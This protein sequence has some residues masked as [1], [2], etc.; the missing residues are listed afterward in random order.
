[1]ISYNTTS[2]YQYNNYTAFND[3]DWIRTNLWKV[4]SDAW[5]LEAEHPTVNCDY[6]REDVTFFINNL[7]ELNA[8]QGQVLL[9]NYVLTQDID[10]N[11]SFTKSIAFNLGVFDGNDYKIMNIK[12]SSGKN[13]SFIACNYGVV[14]NLHIV[15]I[16]FTPTVDGSMKIAGIAGVNK[17]LIDLCSVDDVSVVLT[18]SGGGSLYIGGISAINYGK[19]DNSDANVSYELEVESS[20]SGYSVS[21]LSVYCYVGGIAGSNHGCI[22]FCHTETNISTSLGTSY[23]GGL[24][25]YNYNSILS[26]SSSGTLDLSGHSGSNSISNFGGLVGRSDGNIETSSSSAT[27]ITVTTYQTGEVG[28]LVGLNSGVINNCY[29]SG[30]VTASTSTNSP[31]RVDAGGLVGYNSKFIYNSYATG[32]V[33]ATVN[34]R[35]TDYYTSNTWANCYVGGLVGSGNSTYNGEITIQNC[36]AT[37]NVSG[38]TNTAS[39]Q[40]IAIGGLVGSGNCTNSYISSTQKITTAK[41]TSYG[42]T[43]GSTPSNTTAESKSLSAIRTIEFYTDVLGW[44]AEIWE[45]SN[46]AYPTLK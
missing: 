39:S 10:T 38:A 12:Q 33:S 42:T 17:G 32:N 44:S 20:S 41:T 36:F 14:T 34:G 40:S 13:L 43:T 5:N 45:F 22:Q 9:H 35:K 29:A 2:G 30:S 11:G 7:D 31:A 18:P 26:C 23:I 46:G 6:F 25:G 4:E 24:V 16:E 27:L 19:I 37:G 15:S 28:G 8:L 21:G 1:M 3:I